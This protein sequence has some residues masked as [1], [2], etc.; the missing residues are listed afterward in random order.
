MLL[1]N[2]YC[3]KALETK[4]PEDFFFAVIRHKINA[5]QNDHYPKVT[6]IVHGIEVVTAVV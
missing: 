1:Y 2:F 6:Y 3:C 4:M 5:N